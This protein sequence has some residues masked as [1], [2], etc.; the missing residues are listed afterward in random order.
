M[1]SASVAPNQAP[2]AAFTSSKTF[3]AAT[4]D[5]SGSTD[6]DGTIAGYSWDFGDSTALGSGDNPSHTYA[7]A[8]TY[9]VTLT[10]TDDDGATGTISHDI[11]VAAE[12]PNQAPTAAFTSSS[13]FLAASF[14]GTGSTDPDGTIAGYAWNFGDNT[15]AGSWGQAV[16]HLRRGGHLPGDVDG[17]RRRRRHR[18]HSPRTSPSPPSRS[19]P[20][21]TSSA[22][23]RAAGV[24]SIVGG[25]WGPNSTRLA[26]NGNAATMSVTA[27]VGPGAYLSGVSAR[28]VDATVKVAFDKVGTGS[29]LYSALDVRRIGT[30][31]YRLKV[32][33]MGNTVTTYLVRTVDGVETTL[34]T[35]AGPN[36]PTGTYLHLRLR[37]FG[38]GTTTLQGKVWVDGAAEPANP[39][40]TSHR[41]HGGAAE[42]GHRRRVHL[43]VGL[44]HQRTGRRQLRRLHRRPVCGT[45]MVVVEP[46]E[47]RSVTTADRA[48]ERPARSA[49]AT[50]SAA[51]LHRAGCALQPSAGWRRRAPRPWRASRCSSSSPGTSASKAWESS[52]SSS[53]SSC[54][55][56][57]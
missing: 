52:R 54:S 48:G 3:L 32:R 24:R 45:L 23:W 57:R 19:W 33:L 44:G 8:G 55:P 26:V 46:R 30:S 37:A 34:A 12:P 47:G 15:A 16:A 53:V 5:G 9:T 7:A 49:V 40:L 25:N 6:P 50:P 2:T 21:T 31:D 51:V 10:V 38:T 11:T 42:P 28:D 22:P 43:P 29:G 14:D 20:G 4:F 17:D 41:H 39:T 35:A 13:T 1:T 27:G 56:P 36:L 18:H